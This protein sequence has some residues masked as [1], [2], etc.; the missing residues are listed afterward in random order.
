ML[1]ETEP[2]PKKPK[3][4]SS[5][6]T[7][8][9]RLF[10]EGDGRSPWSRRYRD[11]IAGHVSDLGGHDTLSEATEE[12]DPSRQRDQSRIGAMPRPALA[13]RTGSIIDVFTGAPAVICAASSRRWGS[14][15]APR[16]SRA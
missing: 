5:A 11:L 3:R 4:K 10:V 6:V 7:S 12:P 9:R 1:S 14:R 15:D 2:G 16:T 8:G 13:G